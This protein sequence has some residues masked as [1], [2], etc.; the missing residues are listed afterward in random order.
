MKRVLEPELMEGADQAKAYSQADF[1]LS[2]KKMVFRLEDFISSIGKKITSESLIVDLG[3]GPGN[4][5]ERLA[6]LWPSSSVLGID[7][8]IEML[9]IARKRKENFKHSKRFRNLSYLHANINLISDGRID[10]GI[11]PDVF[12]SNSLL[13]H[14]HNPDCLWNVIKRMGNMSSVVFHRD[15]R[16]PSSLEEAMLLK[17]KYQPNSSEILN[18]DFLASLSAAFNVSEV[19]QQIKKAGLCQL[20][21]FEVDDRYL[22][23]VGVL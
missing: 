1:S 4:I 17:D 9:K 22:E 21:V 6:D 15:L 8:S 2:D 10:L 11:S 5:S 7:G 19:N 18:R 16:R 14:I 23:V 20:K 3:C 12:V 13:H